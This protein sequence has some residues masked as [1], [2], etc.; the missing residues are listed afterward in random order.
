MNIVDGDFDI[1]HA[2]ISSFANMP[3]EVSGNFK[4]NGVLVDTL[5]GIPKIGGNIM[6]DNCK[7][8]HNV[9]A[10]Q[11]VVNGN[12]SMH[13]CGFRT[14]NLNNTTEIKG[15]LFLSNNRIEAISSDMNLR[16]GQSLVLS[17]N[18]IT[19]PNMFTDKIL[20]ENYDFS[21]NPC[22]SQDEWET[23]CNW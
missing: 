6:M 17:D 3:V 9:S 19:N 15:S 13:A 10:I 16:V 1:S 5:S 8:L 4:A 22:M 18:L 21:G 14:L 7:R 2:Q 23:D 20:A 11:S 12:V